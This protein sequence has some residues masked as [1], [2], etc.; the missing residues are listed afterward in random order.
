MTRR[1]VPDILSG[2]QQSLQEVWRWHEFQRALVGEEKSRVLDAPAGGASLAMSR[3]VGKTREELEGDF[4]YQIAEL[5]QLTMLGML[6]S[7][8]AA[9]RVDFIERVRNKKKDKVSR[10]FAD[11]SK[12]RLWNAFRPRAIQNIRLEEDILDTWREHGPR[13][14]EIKR[15]VEEFKGALNLRHWLAHGR[16][17]KP[18]LGR[19]GGYD[20]VDVFEIC[21]ELLQAIDLML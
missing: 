20:P 5:A 12:A 14:R 4:A 6:A 10:R 1:W 9:L 19:T 11:A 3:Y 16:Y 7:T 21:R 13:P 8:E 17:W 18:Q 2:D 15:A